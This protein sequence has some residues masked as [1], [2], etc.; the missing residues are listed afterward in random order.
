MKDAGQDQV[1]EWINTSTND[2]DNLNH[3]KQ[4][5]SGMELDTGVY[6]H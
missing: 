3:T 1:V 6:E 5:N 2:D 4:V